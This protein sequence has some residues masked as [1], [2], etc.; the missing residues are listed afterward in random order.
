MITRRFTLVA[1]AIALTFPVRSARADVFSEQ[2]D[3]GD[4]PVTS[5][6]TIGRGPL[7]SIFGTLLDFQDADMFAIRISDPATFAATTDRPATA[8]FDT[9]LFLFDLHGRG[10]LA[11]DD[12]SHGP[13]NPRSLLAAGGPLGTLTVGLYYLA[14][15]GWDRDPHSGG[16]AIFNDDQFYIG[17]VGPAGPGG[18]GSLTGW[19]GDG[20]LNGGFGVYQIDLSGAEFAITPEP[21]TLLLL[22]LGAAL[23]TPWVCRPAWLG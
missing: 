1:A 5:Q 7:T 13:Y 14:I 23:A 2:S 8:A 10:A 16:A 11:N 4:L 12:I 3:A 19:E 15:S 17:T 6:F 9:Q 21:G 18:G 22:A 20:A